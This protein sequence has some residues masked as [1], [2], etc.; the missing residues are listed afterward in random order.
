MSEN[1]SH[2]VSLRAGSGFSVAFQ[3]PSN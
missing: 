1:H 3:L 2:F